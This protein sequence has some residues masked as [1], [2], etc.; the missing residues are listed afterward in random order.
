MK[1]SRK[2]SVN[3][4]AELPQ[5]FAYEVLRALLYYRYYSIVMGQI[6]PTH[7][8]PAGHHRR[9]L[10]L[11]CHYGVRI[12]NIPWYTSLIIWSFFQPLPPTKS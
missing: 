10:L 12:S 9:I 3:H 6:I 5:C 11:M 7:A 8:T 4:N 2:E 1:A